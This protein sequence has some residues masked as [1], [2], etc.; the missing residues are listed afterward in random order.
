MRLFKRKKQVKRKLRRGITLKQKRELE[1]IEYKHAVLEG[2]YI[3]LAFNLE[4][5]RKGGREYTR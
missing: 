5:K 3:D 2:Q 4:S 1:A